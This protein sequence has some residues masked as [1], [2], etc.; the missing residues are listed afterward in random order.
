M[1]SDKVRLHD[2]NLIVCVCYSVTLYMSHALFWCVH[3]L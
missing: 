3:R 2:L 1:K